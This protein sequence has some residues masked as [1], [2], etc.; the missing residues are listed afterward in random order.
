MSNLKHQY[1]ELSI[2]LTKSL[3]KQEK[4]DYGIFIKMNVISV[5]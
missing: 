4:K 1:S 2:S 5:F 3:S